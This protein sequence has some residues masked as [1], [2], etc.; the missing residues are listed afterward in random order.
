MTPSSPSPSDY[1]K[2]FTVYVKLLS[3]SLQLTKNGAFIA[4]ELPVGSSIEIL[5][6]TS[7][8]ETESQSGEER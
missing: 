7:E 1:K 4:T 5:R 3:L 8:S 2:V 6:V